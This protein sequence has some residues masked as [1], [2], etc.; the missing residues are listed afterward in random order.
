[1]S[2]EKTSGRNLSW[3]DT[4]ARRA[5]NTGR[6][7]EGRMVI[8]ATP[9]LARTCAEI[10]REY[11][12][13]S[14]P[15]SD[16]R[17]EE[18]MRAASPKAG[19]RLKN[20][21]GPLLFLERAECIQFS[22]DRCA[23]L[24]LGMDTMKI[25][26]REGEVLWPEEAPATASPSERA[27]ERPARG[28]RRRPPGAQRRVRLSVDEVREGIGR[29]FASTGRPFSV[30]QAAAALFMA[31]GTMQGRMHALVKEGFLKLDGPGEFGSMLYALANA[32]PAAGET[33]AVT[34]DGEISPNGGP[35]TAPAPAPVGEIGRGLAGRGLAALGQY[36][37]PSAHRPVKTREQLEQD[38][39]GIDARLEDL[40]RESLRL[41]ELRE[42]TVR[43]IAD[44]DAI[45]GIIV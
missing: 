24:P 10:F 45:V 4:D 14:V 39:A 2:D 41:R 19:G 5:F 22:E 8:Q 18:F 36:V 42:R 38:L 28:P 25:V 21:R 3:K 9:T 33:A 43:V 32:E 6:V 31:N 40:V 35:D 26:T 29:T 17:C 12:R 44:Y 13:T 27:A 30:K 37:E 16:V 23:V 34:A 15:L 1:M 7:E 20:A 11:A